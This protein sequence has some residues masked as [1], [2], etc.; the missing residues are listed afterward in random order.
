MGSQCVILAGGLGTRMRQLSSSVPKALLPVNGTPFI[1]HQLGWIGAHGV[2]EVVLSIGHLGQQLREHVGTGE[3]YGLRVL[4]VDEGEVLR[5]TAGALR[6][7]LDAGALRER[8]LLTYGDSYL[9]IDFGAFA[10]AFE[11]CGAPAMMTVVRNEGRWDKSNT[12]VDG[13]SIV[14]YDKRPSAADYA[15]MKHIDYGLLAFERGLIEQRV[16]AGARA[17]LA[18]VLHRLSLERSLGAYEVMDR[19]YE[20]GSMQ[21]LADLEALLAP[22]FAASDLGLDRE[23][24]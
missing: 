11:R 4:F 21:G 9:P 13:G 22:C 23:E 3:R 1:D 7:A 16:Q 12:I 6:F 20:I 8:F 10:A 5:G 19:F 2:D 17:D 18:D 14:L 15:R 24:R